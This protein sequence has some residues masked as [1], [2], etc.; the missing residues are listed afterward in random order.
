MKTS[1]AASDYLLSEEAIDPKM[2]SKYSQLAI[3]EQ[4][5]QF[6]SNFKKFAVITDD[7][8]VPT[9]LEKIV[10]TLQ[11]FNEIGLGEVT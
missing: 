7:N 8:S 1:T 6:N 11:D 4:L 2:I 3:V 10:H 9:A 5:A